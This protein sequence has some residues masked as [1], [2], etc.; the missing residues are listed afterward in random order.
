MYTGHPQCL[1]ELCFLSYEKSV[2]FSGRIIW[3]LPKTTV[4]LPPR[5]L[6]TSDILVWDLTSSRLHSSLWEPGVSTWSMTFSVFYFVYKSD[7]EAISQYTNRQHRIFGLESE[8]AE[9]SFQSHQ[10]FNLLSRWHWYA[11]HCPLPNPTFPKPSTLKLNSLLVDKV[12]LQTQ[13]PGTH[14]LPKSVSLPLALPFCVQEG[15]VFTK[16]K[17]KLKFITPSLRVFFYLFPD[18]VWTLWNLDLATDVGRKS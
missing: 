5:K 14:L 18:L 7:L 4:K 2:V 13:S 11:E 17:D 15:L 9:I 16:T 12:F 8:T 1:S 3:H 6:G 10:P